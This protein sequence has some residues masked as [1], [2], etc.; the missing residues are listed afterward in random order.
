MRL[1]V[2]ILK[3]MWNSFRIQ[4]LDLSIEWWDNWSLGAWFDTR[5]FL[6]YGY[7]ES[8]NY[9]RIGRLVILWPN[10]TWIKL[11]TALVIPHLLMLTVNG[12]LPSSVLM[13]FLSQTE[14]QLP[15]HLMTRLLKRVTA[16]AR[17]IAILQMR[18]GSLPTPP[19]LLPQS[20]II[21]IS[22]LMF[23]GQPTVLLVQRGM[24]YYPDYQNL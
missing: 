14:P 13:S 10:R 11:S 5:K 24:N 1:A 21:T 2:R 12:G 3:Y 17:R 6:E 20:Q 7:I 9:L 15:K 22:I 19:R 4:R 8:Q 16:L 23:T 18:Y